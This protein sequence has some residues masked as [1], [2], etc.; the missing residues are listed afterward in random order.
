MARPLNEDR[1]THPPRL[2]K[3]LGQHFLIDSHY[4]ERI[5][6]ESGITGADR[7]LEIGPGS[8]NLTREILSRAG[9][10]LAIELDR[11][12]SAELERI[13]AAWPGRF[14]VVYDDVLHVNLPSLLDGPPAWKVLANI[15]YYITAPILALLLGQG[16]SHISDI[17]LTV[18]KEIA[19]R[20][21]AQ[22][23]SADFSSLTLF[24]AYHSEPRFLFTI[25]PSAFMPPPL[26]HSA[27]IHLKVRDLPAARSPLDLLFRIIHR[28]F[29]QRRKGIKNSLKKAFPELSTEEI[30]AGLSR[31]GIDPLLRPQDISLPQFDALALHFESFDRQGPPES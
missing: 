17:F 20:V 1:L 27:F 23:G 19:E 26:V 9:K 15:P 5:V 10:V 6:R 31:C 2:R 22:P 16:S 14:Q 12:F 21:C 8:G 28:A 25:P 30:A 29:Q 3:S 13:D 18:Q 11:R 24:V 4:L 7:I